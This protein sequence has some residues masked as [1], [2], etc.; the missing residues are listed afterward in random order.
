[1]RYRIRKKGA[2]YVLERKPIDSKWQSRT[3]LPTESLW[4]HLCPD[5]NSQ[6][7][8]QPIGKEKPEEP[9]RIAHDLLT[10][11]LKD[12][13]IGT[14]KDPSDEEIKKSLWEMSK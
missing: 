2:R 6:D 11:H 13:D 12:Q 8:S 9:Q 5:I 10:E 4:K 3:L 1:M 7:V 14:Q